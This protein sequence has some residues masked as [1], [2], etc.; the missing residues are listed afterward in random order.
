[1]SNRCHIAYNPD[2]Q[3]KPLPGIP[4]RDKWPVDKNGFA[5]YHF[6]V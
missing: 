3:C 4:V 5:D 2:C 1:G 6:A